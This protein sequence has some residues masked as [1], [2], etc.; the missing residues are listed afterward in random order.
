MKPCPAS[1]KRCLHAA[2]HRAG[3]VVARDDRVAVVEDARDGAGLLADGL[4]EARVEGIERVPRGVVDGDGA[5]RLGEL[6]GVERECDR[7]REASWSPWR[8]WS[9][10]G[11]SP[12]PPT[13]AATAFSGAEGTASSSLSHGAR[14]T[15]N[16]RIDGCAYGIART[17]SMTAMACVVF[18]RSGCDSLGAGGVGR[19]HRSSRRLVLVDQRARRREGRR[20]EGPF[21]PPVLFNSSLYGAF[22]VGVFIVF[23]LVRRH[24]LA[25]ILLLVAVSYGFY[26]Y[27][28]LDAARNDP[29]PLGPVAVERPLPRHHL[30]RQH[31]RL[32]HRARPREGGA[33]R[34]P[35]GAAARRRSS[36][37]W[38]YLQS[39]STST[40]PSTRSW[41]CCT[42]PAST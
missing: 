39:S 15:R 13:P 5:L 41:T 42:P 34:G 18:P 11:G 29:V 19:W 17:A 7:R 37:I 27:G 16:L 30:R 36:I 10:R 2:S 38:G 1:P 8:C 12:R 25:R 33:P 6:G 40:S 35:Q 14:T 32:R 26:F 28:T 4:R 9:S 3:D 24:R 22:L 23:W 21:A 20:V 31:P